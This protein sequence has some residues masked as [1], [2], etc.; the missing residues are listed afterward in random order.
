[1]PHEQFFLK[2]ELHCRTINSIPIPVVLLFLADFWLRR[3]FLA[4]I[5]YLTSKSSWAN[6]FNQSTN[7]KVNF[8][9]IYWE[10]FFWSMKKCK[11]HW[12]EESTRDIFVFI[13]F[14]ATLM[15]SVDDISHWLCCHHLLRRDDAFS[16]YPSYSPQFSFSW[17]H[18]Q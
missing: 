5:I 11:S 9:T 4:L 7:F 3:N 17:Q 15:S 12:D 14:V 18:N 10:N 16:F 8:W 1:M 6:I 2:L 13:Y